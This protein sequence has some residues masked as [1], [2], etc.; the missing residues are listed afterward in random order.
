MLKESFSVNEKCGIKFL[1][2][3]G[4]MILFLK[5]NWH[6][7][8]QKVT[9]AEQRKIFITMVTLHMRKFPTLSKRKYERRKLGMHY[10]YAVMDPAII[11]QRN[12]L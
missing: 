10:D 9:A 6:L 11:V 12:P 2:G 7:C 3:F 1:K 4:G 5:A 8:T